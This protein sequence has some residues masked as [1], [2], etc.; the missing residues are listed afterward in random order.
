MG[1]SSIFGRKL[2]IFTKRFRQANR[3]SRL[4]QTLLARHSQLMLQVDIGGCQKNMNARTGRILESLPGSFNV[5]GTCAG[6]SSDD[7]PSNGGSH[8]LHGF[9]IA[10]R[11]NGKAGFDHVHAQ[12][13]ELLRHPQLFLDV[14]AAAWRLFAVPQGGVEDR[15]ARSLHSRGPPHRV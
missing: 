1:A 8:G 11:G 14:H 5:H 2:H 6:Q 7:R 13:I 4:L 3:I 15:D 9:E 10:I 12:A